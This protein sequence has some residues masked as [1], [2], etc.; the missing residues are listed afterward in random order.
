MKLALTRDEARAIQ[1]HCFTYIDL[2]LKSEQHNALSMRD[3]VA[4]MNVRIYRS[5]FSDVRIKFDRR[6]IG[7]SNKFRMELKESEA[8]VFVHLLSRVAIDVKNEWLVYTRQRAMDMLTKQIF[9]P[10]DVGQI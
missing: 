6:L 3:E 9:T 5:V 1:L 10:A 8:I 2:Y 7:F 4:E